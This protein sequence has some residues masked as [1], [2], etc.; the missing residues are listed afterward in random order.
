MRGL[1][2][3]WTTSGD[4]SKI[5]RA[6]ADSIESKYATDKRKGARDAAHEIAL[7]LRET[8]KDL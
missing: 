5:L 7:A 1:L 3:R 2:P 8:A 6:F 4:A